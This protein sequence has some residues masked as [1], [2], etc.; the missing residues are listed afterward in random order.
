L[1][2]VNGRIAFLIQKYTMS[3]GSVLNSLLCYLENTNKQFPISN[4]T[5]HIM[6]TQPSPNIETLLPTRNVSTSIVFHK[7][8]SILTLHLNTYLIMY[9][10][11]LDQN[12]NSYRQRICKLNHLHL[13]HQHQSKTW[14]TWFWKIEICSKRKGILCIPFMFYRKHV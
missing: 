11:I 7:T 13:H 12:Q 2:G 1:S 5:R 4:G 9:H 10:Y 14:K 8:V 3:P 6:M